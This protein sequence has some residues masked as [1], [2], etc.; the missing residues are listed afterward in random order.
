[1]LFSFVSERHNSK[2]KQLIVAI[3]MAKKQSYYLPLIEKSTLYGG[4]Q[5]PSRTN[6]VS[7]STRVW[8]V[9]SWIVI[10]IH[11]RITEEHGRSTVENY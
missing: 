9:C 4:L 7:H 3:G 6:L 2:I 5:L 10:N 11:R 1:M 8:L